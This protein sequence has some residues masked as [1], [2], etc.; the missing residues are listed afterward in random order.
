MKRPI[1]DLYA[2]YAERVLPAG[3]DN[4]QKQETKRAFYAGAHALFE[5]VVFKSD[6][7]EEGMQYMTEIQKDAELFCEEIKKGKA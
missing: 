2:T 6:N 3:A 1:A 5:M 7:E 4:I